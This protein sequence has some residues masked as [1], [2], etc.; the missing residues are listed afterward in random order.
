[1][2]VKRIIKSNNKQFGILE[3]LRSTF[4]NNIRQYGMLIALVAIMIFFQITTKGILLVPMNV[5]NLILQNS[6]VLILAIGM[7]LCIVAGGHIDLS[8][9]S[10]V[11]LVGAVVGILV[12]NLKVDVWVG[13]AV[14]LL[15]GLIVGLWQ[16]FWIAYVRIPSFIVTL[17]GMLIFRGLTITILEGLTLLQ[18]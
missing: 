14:G 10:M 12:M 1:M 16:G 5:T 11:A 17:A 13:I 2:E 7:T 4:R 6:Y 15:M 18:A 9:G 3:T 8:A